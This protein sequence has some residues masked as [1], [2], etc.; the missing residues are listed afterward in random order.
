[1]FSSDIK[2]AVRISHNLLDSEIDRIEGYARAEMIRVGVPE[3]QI[4]ADNELIRNAVVTRGIMELGPERS[5]D[6]AKESWEYQ[7][8]NIRKH[9][10]GNE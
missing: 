6:K 5:Y 8:D 4:R 9:D 1:M 10:W 7:L 2:K 3:N